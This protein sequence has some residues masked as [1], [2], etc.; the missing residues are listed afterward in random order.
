MV[1]FVMAMMAMMAIT[2]TMMIIF[3]AP[4]STLTTVLGAPTT[5]LTTSSTTAAVRR[6]FSFYVFNLS[7]L[8]LFL[9]FSLS[10][11]LFLFL[12]LTQSSRKFFHSLSSYSPNFSRQPASAPHQL[13]TNQNPRVTTAQSTAGTASPSSP[14]WPTA[15]LPSTLLLHKWPT[16]SSL[17]TMVPARSGFDVMVFCLVA[18]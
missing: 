5:S 15:S 18:L 3:S 1:V 16:I 7:S 13:T 6:F 12:S 4:A 8:S 14:R 10:L 2:T 17:P 9:P 11:S